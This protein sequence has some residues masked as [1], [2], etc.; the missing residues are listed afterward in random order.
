MPAAL[1]NVATQDSYVDATTVT[2]MRARAG[3]TIQ[4]NNAAVYYQVGHLL[5]GIPAV[6]WEPG[7]HFL[8]PSIA[9]FKDPALEGLPMGAMFGA[10][11]LRSAAAGVPA[12][13]SVA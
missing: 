5:P 4:V 8:Q 11:R 7:E 3:F 6:N 2:F 9:A 13:V 10:V 1:N 12:R